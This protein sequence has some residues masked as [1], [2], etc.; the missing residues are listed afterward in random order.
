MDRPVLDLAGL[1]AVMR[2]H[3]VRA[4]LKRRLAARGARGVRDRLSGRPDPRLFFL[5]R[6]PL[7]QRRSLLA[8]NLVDRPVLEMTH[9]RAVLLCTAARARARSRLAADLAVV[10][11]RARRRESRRLSRRRTRRRTSS[12]GTARGRSRRRRASLG[13]TELRLRLRFSLRGRLRGRRRGGGRGRR[14]GRC[15][16]GCR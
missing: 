15:G 7:L 8:R 2:G 11:G 14:G 4:R 16:G 5:L 1:A 3:A 6:K 10:A 9:A 13:G 12:R